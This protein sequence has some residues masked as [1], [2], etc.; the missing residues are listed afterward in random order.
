MEVFSDDGDESPA[1]SAGIKV[2]SGAA[3]RMWLAQTRDRVT[4][5]RFEV[6]HGNVSAREGVAAI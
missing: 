4:D 1:G 3:K 5:R 2:S 6:G